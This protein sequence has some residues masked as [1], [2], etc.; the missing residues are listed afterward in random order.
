[1]ELSGGLP[2]GREIEEIE[3]YAPNMP[4]TPAQLARNVTHDFGV[5]T[6]SADDLESHGG[7]FLSAQ[8]GS[9]PSRVTADQSILSRLEDKASLMRKSSTQEKNLSK[10]VGAA[11]KFSGAVVI[12]EEEEPDREGREALRKIQVPFPIKCQRHN[13]RR[14]PS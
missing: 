12:D 13:L 14:M 2:P 4:R 5:S 3:D 9:N 10:T 7:F 8:K 1:M 11:P 6:F